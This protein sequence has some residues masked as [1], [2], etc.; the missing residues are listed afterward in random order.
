MC[1]QK[2]QTPVNKF[3]FSWRDYSFRPRECKYKAK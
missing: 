1:L 3:T 2:K